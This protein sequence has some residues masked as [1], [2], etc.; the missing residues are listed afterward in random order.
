MKS[1]ELLSERASYEQIDQ[2]RVASDEVAGMHRRH[3]GKII[4]VVGM[5]LTFFQAVLGF[6]LII[7]AKPAEFAA[8]LINS[9]EKGTAIGAESSLF[10]FGFQALIAGV[11]AVLLGAAALYLTRDEKRMIFAGLLFIVA[12]TVNSVVLFAA[13]LP[14]GIVLMAAGIAVLIRK[15]GKAV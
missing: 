6:F 5:A 11:A 10:T 13:G 7:F 12:G 3:V 4:A 9:G 15:P 8:V 2:N 14:C 1:K